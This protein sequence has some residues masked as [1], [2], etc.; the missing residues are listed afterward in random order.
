LGSNKKLQAFLHGHISHHHGI[1]PISC[2]ILLI[3]LVFA[4]RTECFL[5][6]ILAVYPTTKSAQLLSSAIHVSHQSIFCVV[7]TIIFRFFTGTAAIRETFQYLTDPT[8]KRLGSQAWA[9]IAILM[10]ETLICIKFGRNEFH[11]PAP[12]NVIVFWSLFT[13]LLVMY[14]TWQFVIAP[15]LEKRDS[16]NVKSA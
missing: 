3:S 11:E 6:E 12:W 13:A 1:K 14:A 4:R 15:Y 9:S 16:K 10:T 2:S 5:L 8:C 7:S